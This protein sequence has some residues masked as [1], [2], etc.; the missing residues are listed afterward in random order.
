MVV[1]GTGL[2]AD[3]EAALDA[4]RPDARLCLRIAEEYHRRGDRQQAFRWLARVVDASDQFVE[5]S[6]AASMLARLAAEERPLARRQ[7]RIALTGSYTLKPFGALLRLAALREGIDVVLH[8]SGYD[9]Y[10]QELLDGASPLYRFEPSHIVI[11]PHAGE[12]RFSDPGEEPSLR[13]SREVER[14]S[15]LWG[16]ARLHSNATVVQHLFVLRPEESLGHLSARLQGSRYSLTRELNRALAQD[17]P[18]GVLVVD[19]ERIA[20]DFGKRQWFDDRYWHMTKQAVALDALPL[21]ARHT[22]AVLAASLGLSRKCLVLDLDGTLWG[23]VVGDDGLPGIRLGT[24]ADGEAFVAFQEYVLEL[25]SRGIVLA[26]VSKNDDAVARLPFER[27]PDMRIKLDDIAVFRA[28]WDDK[29]TNLTAIAQSLGI[30]LDALTFVDDNVLER[31]LVRRMLPEVD[32]VDLPEDPSAYVR[33]MADYLRFETVSL[34]DEDLN[35]TEQYRARNAVEALRQ[36]TVSLDEFL[37]SLKMAAYVAPFDELHL[38]R[39]AQLMGKTNQFNLT[40]LRCSED[41]LRRLMGDPDAVHLYLRLKDRFTDHGL[42]A[43]LIGRRE[44]S[45]MLIESWLMSCRVIGRAVEE[46][47]LEELC[48]RAT[49]IGCARLRGSYIPSGRNELVRDLYPRLGFVQAGE[50]AWEL[51]LQDRTPAARSHIGAW[52]GK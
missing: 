19:L 51:D 7:A 42:V 49:A 33:R 8:E 13:L 31:Q 46:W 40:G 38:P 37:A 27:H 43:V 34:T 44:G 12:L 52:D 9:Q 2:E 28:N 29:A 35:R 26:V 25:K 18:E 24:G 4:E 23:G 32:V 16:A 21:I 1:T 50:D 11:A 22:A 6:G 14:W 5:W 30:G 41:E 36:S 17:A 15:A 47:M 20:A 48:L 10:R 39:I 3:L 45:L